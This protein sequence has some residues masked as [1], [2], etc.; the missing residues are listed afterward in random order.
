MRAPYQLAPTPC[1]SICEIRDGV[2]PEVGRDGQVERVVFDVEHERDRITA[3]PRGT[4]R[5]RP[6][7]AV[8][9]SGS[10]PSSVHTDHARYW[11]AGT[12]SSVVVFTA[13]A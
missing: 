4:R 1:F 11:E 12:R 5:V 3:R 10:D 8:Q 6:G 9:P 7:G 2:T 13:N